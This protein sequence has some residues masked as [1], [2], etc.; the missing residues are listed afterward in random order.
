MVRPWAES[1][2][3]PSAMATTPRDVVRRLLEAGVSGDLA[4]LCERQDVELMVL[5]GSAARDE[6]DPSDVDLAARFRS[7]GVAD[8]LALLQ[9]LYQLTTYEGFDLLDLGRAGPVARDRALTGCRLLYEAAPGLYARAQ[10]AAAMERMDTEEL[11][12]VELELL[13]R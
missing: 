6:P 7:G 8:P 5:F 11:R 9:D 13:A 1:A 2:H 10:I 3:Y 12:R 4:R